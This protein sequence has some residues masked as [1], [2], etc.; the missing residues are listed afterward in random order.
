MI[1]IKTNRII[2]I[3]NSRESSDVAKW[4]KSFPNIKIVSRDGSN[5]YAK[6]IKS[7]N[8]NAVQINDRFHII[9]NL[10]EYLKSYI[11]KK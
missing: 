11:T 6:A 1:D 3:L 9:K 7:A 4:L 10:T 5:E 8:P 2:D